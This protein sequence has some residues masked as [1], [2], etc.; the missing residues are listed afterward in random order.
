MTLE[1]EKGHVLPN[2]P[3]A[4]PADRPIPGIET[5]NLPH[6]EMRHSIEVIPV[7]DR[8]AH[9]ECHLALVPEAVHRP[10]AALQERL[11]ALDAPV[12]SPEQDPS[13]VEDRRRHVLVMTPVGGGILPEQLPSP[14]FHSRKGLVVPL[15]HLSHSRDLHKKR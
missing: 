9:V 1:G 3:F 14:T 15:H 4:E 8:R 5:E 13:L 11:Q 6:L 7:D 12:L 10:L 2:P